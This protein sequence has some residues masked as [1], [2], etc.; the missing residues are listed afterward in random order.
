MKRSLSMVIVFLF[1]NM[2]LA[3]NAAN[4]VNSF[5]LDLYRVLS[6]KEG[7]IF[8]SP[9]SISTA[10]AM[11]YLGADG[12][13][14]LQMKQVLHF[15]D[16][17]LHESFSKLIASLNKPAEGYKLSIANA[18]WVQR[19]YPLLETFLRDIDSYYRAPVNTVD[20][21]T[22]LDNSI[23]KVND[24]IEEKTA[25]KI[26]NMLTRDDVD[27]LTRL[28]LT[29]AIYFKGKWKM[30]FDEKLTKKDFFY[31]NETTKVE[32]DMM[33]LTEKFEYYEDDQVQ[34]LKLPYAGSSLSM[35]IVLPKVS[36]KLMELEKDLTKEKIEGWLKNLSETRVQLFLPRFKIQ[37]RLSMKETL[38]KMGMIDPFTDR[39]D[40]SKIDGTRKLKIQNVIHQAFVEVNEE[41]TEAA[42][43]TAVI[44]GIKMAMPVM[45]VIFRADRP[46]MF[47]IQEE[48]SN[49]ILFMGRLQKP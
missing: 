45:P 47:F 22:D 33:E 39:A 18:L 5:G 41:G 46:F 11:T 48:T 19:N 14:A 26:K 8:F 42:A 6:G 32:V 49:T 13:T 43:A 27:S 24:W 28:I 3:A 4:S 34:V 37:Q 40:F 30:P 21:V 16:E 38:M 35:L 36:V 1:I 2:C 29:N 12:N 20:F 25:G 23:R 10:L 44:M 15:E 9:F 17:G 7:N 31:E